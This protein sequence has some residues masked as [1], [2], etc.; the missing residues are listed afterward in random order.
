MSELSTTRSRLVLLG[1]TGSIGTQALEVLTRLGASAP[2]LAA[3]AAGGSRLDLL[4]E[5][6]V[7]FGV[8]ILALSSD[9]ALPALR[10]RFLFCWYFC[11]R[12]RRVFQGRSGHRP[13]RLQRCP[14]KVPRL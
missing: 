13:E 10:W 2:R 11:W 4:A 14:S 7:A 8:P 6:A 9:D 12:L 1:S 5:Q 3:L